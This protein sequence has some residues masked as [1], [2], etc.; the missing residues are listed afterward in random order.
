M[1][2]Q[3][4]SRTPICKMLAAGFQRSSSRAS[5]VSTPSLAL[6]H[7]IEDRLADGDL[8]VGV[9]CPCGCGGPWAR[10][11]CVSG[12]ISMM[13]PRSASTHSKINCMIRCSNWSM[14]SVWLTASAV[15]YMTC[16]L[17][18]GA[19]QP[20]VCGSSAS[21]VEDPAPL[22]LRH[23]ADDPRAVARL[24]R[25]DDVDD[26]GQVLV[27][28]L[29]R[30]G[31]QHQRAADLQLVAAAEPVAADPLAVDEGAVGA[32]QV[33]ERVASLVAA[34]FGMLAGD[35]GVV[36]LDGVGRRRAP[37]GRSARPAR[38]ACPD[39]FRG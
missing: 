19:G 37:A 22:L 32:A 39:R 17:L 1:G 20:G 11:A 25:R 18:A 13:Q 21:S 10:A 15:R 35:F 4:A 38:S 36:E 2:T 34:D 31:E 24:R 7:V 29:G 9:R 14:S 5:L 12:S 3:I 6:D 33:G 28:S 26:V 23:R 16:R 30:A 8:F 27:G